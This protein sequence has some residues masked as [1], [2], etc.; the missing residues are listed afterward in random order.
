LGYGIEDRNNVAI[1]AFKGYHISLYRTI[2][3]Q[4]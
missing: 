3:A 4:F 2:D 1:W